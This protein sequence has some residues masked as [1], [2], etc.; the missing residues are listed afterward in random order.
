MTA[1]MATEEFSD[2][3]DAE[4]F[5]RYLDRIYMTRSLG[6]SEEKIARQQ[7][8][9]EQGWCFDRAI[10]RNGE[11]HPPTSQDQAYQCGADSWF[12][13]AKARWL[14]RNWRQFAGYVSRRFAAG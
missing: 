3:T 2:I 13:D 4:S 14:W 12:N 8:R 1:T 10:G 9:D 5:D 6:V 11:H 7:W